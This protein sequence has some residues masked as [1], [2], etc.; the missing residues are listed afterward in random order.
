MILQKTALQRAHDATFGV[1]QPGAPLP[2]GHTIGPFGIRTSFSRPT[3]DSASPP[4]EDLLTRLLKLKPE[5]P[6]LRERLSAVIGQLAPLLSEAD[7]VEQAIAEEWMQSLKAKHTEVRAQGRKQSRFC[8]RLRQELKNAEAQ[9]LTAISGQ[10]GALN[11]FQELGALEQRGQHVPPWATDEE[12]SVWQREIKKA[13]AKVA[14][15]NEWAA[16]ALRER[17]EVRLRLEPAEKE[18]ARLGGEEIR[19]RKTIAGE[20]FLDPEYGLVT[21]PAT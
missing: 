9:L 20:A 7:K 17:E 8:V 4:P 5:T 11:A 6:E 13:Q 12:L 18:L 2:E 14:E 16:S 21:T 19:L 10:Q 15:A 3:P 1:S